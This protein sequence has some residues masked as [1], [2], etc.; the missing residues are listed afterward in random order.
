M[1]YNLVWAFHI[2]NTL[3]ENPSQIGTVFWNMVAGF[4]GSEW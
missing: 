1:S 4:C 3:L 2:I